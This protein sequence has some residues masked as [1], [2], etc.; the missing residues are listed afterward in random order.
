MELRFIDYGSEAYWAAAKLRYR[1][2][3]QPH[4]IAESIVQT[5]DDAQALHVVIQQNRSVL[6]YGQLAHPTGRQFTVHQM[7]VEPAWQRQGLGRLVLQALLDRAKQLGGRSVS[8]N[9]RVAQLGF[10]SA[11]ASKREETFLPRQRLGLTTSRWKSCWSHIL[12]LDAKITRVPITASKA[13]P[14]I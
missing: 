12:S 8:L 14:A 9:A 13:L 4:G 10:T 3:Y 2:F 1:L 7:V 11:W 5:G 6:A